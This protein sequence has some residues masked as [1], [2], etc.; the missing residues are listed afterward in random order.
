MMTVNEVSK[1]TGVSI[2]TLQYYDQI[3]LLKPTQYTES[4]YRLYD[5]AA[6]EKLQQ[7]LLFRELEFPLK[8]IKE[9][10]SRSDFDEKK[11]LEQQIELLELKKEHI[12]N[13]LNMCKYLKK[14]GVKK[15]NF[16]AFDTSKLDEYAQKAKEQ[17]GDTAAYKEFENKSKGRTKEQESGLM[18]DLSKVF[19]E[20]GAMKGEEPG[21]DRAQAQVKKLQDFITKNFYTC[22]DEILYGLGT[23]YVAGG[24]MTDN[25][26]KMGGAGTAQ[27]VFD[28]IK[29][30]C[31]K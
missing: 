2:R 31:G 1:L 20:F 8:D 28:A 12:E 9:I 29:V 24:E 30:H 10:V 6:L 7:I 13:L 25:I 19:E 15:L 18:A 5:D 3:K 14:R 22:T 26:E 27:F 17:W 23:G 21:S 16:S 4:G 11:A